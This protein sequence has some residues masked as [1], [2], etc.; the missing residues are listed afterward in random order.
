MEFKKKKN[1]SFFFCLTGTV[2][3]FFFMFPVSDS[4]V[5][6]F[7][8]YVH[9]SYVRM[10][11]ILFF[12]FDPPSLYF[13]RHIEIECKF[14]DILSGRMIFNV[15]ISIFFSFVFFLNFFVLVHDE[16]FPT[17]VTGS[18]RL[19][20]ACHCSIFFP[21]KKRKWKFFFKKKKRIEFFPFLPYS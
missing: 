20:L 2:L 10:I 3:F 1:I 4:I 16:I 8:L 12:F 17:R 6:L 11:R 21:E 19:N 9:M 7:I 13:S 14:S 5:S 15:S 18:N